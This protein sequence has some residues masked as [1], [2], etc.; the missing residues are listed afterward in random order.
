[1]SD[2]KMKTIGLLILLSLLLCGCNSHE[3][4]CNELIDIAK[5]KNVQNILRSWVHAK[6]SKVEDIRKTIGSGYGVW[7]GDF[8][9]DEEFPWS[10]IG[11]NRY[12]QINLV[13]PTSM[14][15][16]DNIRSIFF[17][18]V[19]RY[20]ILIKPNNSLSFGVDGKFL[21]EIS[22]DVAVVCRKQ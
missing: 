15:E 12:S 18:E 6:F 1:M 5:K 19:S 9:F 2:S 21:V 13:G 7:P 4:K 22:D 14:D 3:T 20:G 8:S 11:F 17:G 16:L 10:K